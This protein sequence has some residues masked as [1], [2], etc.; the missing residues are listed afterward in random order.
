MKKYIL[1]II[2]IVPV[3]IIY[4]AMGL[5]GRRN[6]VNRQS[7]PEKNK[8]TLRIPLF[9]RIVMLMLFCFISIISLYILIFQLEDWPYILIGMGFF[10]MPGLIAFILLSL[11]KIEIKDD[12]FIYR[13]YFG[14]KRIQI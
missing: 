7:N 2:A 14:K 4:V 11:W 1:P 8:T 3:I 5:Y 13:N 10:G 12:G 9:Y 6:K